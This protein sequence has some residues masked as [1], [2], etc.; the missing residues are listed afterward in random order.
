MGVRTLTSTI[1]RESFLCDRLTDQG[2]DCSSDGPTDRP[3]QSN[4]A[5]HA[6]E[7]RTAKKGAREQISTR[8]V[9]WAEK[10]VPLGALKRHTWHTLKKNRCRLLG[11]VGDPSCHPAEGGSGHPAAR[12]QARQPA[13]AVAA[14][15]APAHPGA[16]AHEGGAHQ[17]PR[18]VQPRIFQRRL[19][20]TICLM[21]NLRKIRV[22]HVLAFGPLA[23]PECTRVATGETGRLP[24][25]PLKR[26]LR[27]Q[28]KFV[29]PPGCAHT[30]S[31]A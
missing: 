4:S 27:V 24:Q 8:L 3:T 15:A 11:G 16:D 20:F 23:L 7:P 9:L 12:G 26:G 19:V 30:D 21:R 13:D 10:H 17:I 31:E 22:A 2:T 5:P 1:H 25:V 6:Q 14:G 28:C 29:N 18:D